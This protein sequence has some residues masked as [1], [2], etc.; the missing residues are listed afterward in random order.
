[1]T[2]QLFCFGLIMQLLRNSFLISSIAFFLCVAWLSHQGSAQIV[3]SR[4]VPEGLKTHAPKNFY[5]GGVVHGDT[6]FKSKE[7]LAVAQRD[8][9]AVTSTTYL[10]WGV[11]ENPKKNPD[12]SNFNKVVD[13]AGKRGIRVHGHVMVFPWANSKSEWWQRLP[14]TSVEK[15][16][17]HFVVSAARTR[18]GKVWSWDVVNEVMADDNQPMDADGL[19]TEYKEYRA[20]GPSHVKKAFHWAAAADPNAKLILN[21]TGCE[22]ICG[23]SNRLYK[24]AVKLKSQGVPIH[25]IGFQTHF[26]DV[27]SPAPDIAGMRK[28]F[29]R[30][31]DAGFELHITEI[32]VCAIR[33]KN[34]H[35]GRPGI[36][37]P[38]ADQLNRQRLHFERTLQL[39]L[40]MPAVKSFLLWDYA[41]DFSWL[42]K[43]TS[44]IVNVPK[45][46]YTYPT[47]FWGGKTV[48]MYPKPAYEGMLNVMRSTRKIHR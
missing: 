39:A 15:Y 47:P 23:K 22:R 11:W 34:P 33:T 14:P 21:T 29:Q 46:T 8:F 35:P 6:S 5:I 37:T 17:K 43:T 30:F 48:P 7:Y 4:V 25:G 28:N 18:K 12:F 9:N 16:L 10:P 20:V 36:S 3:S 27:T 44:Q 42:H 41:D 45:D 2:R 32:D 24:Y 1:M 38:N 13:W 40:S 31:A 19:R 26:V